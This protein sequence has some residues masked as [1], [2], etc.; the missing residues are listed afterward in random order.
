MEGDDTVEELRLEMGELA[1]QKCCE[2]VSLGSVAERVSR[3]KRALE[4][5]SVPLLD[6]D[7]GMVT[8]EKPLSLHAHPHL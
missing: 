8:Q 7:S 2:G 6:D 5:N 3:F 4:G 1:T